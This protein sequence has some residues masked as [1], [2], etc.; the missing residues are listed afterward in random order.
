ML[1]SSIQ[2]KLAIG[3]ACLLS[4]PQLEHHTGNAQ[5]PLPPLL[6]PLAHRNKVVRAVRKVLNKVLLQ[7][8]DQVV[9]WGSSMRKWGAVGAGLS[10][11]WSMKGEGGGNQ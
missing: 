3:L 8:Q 11:G 4:T 6:E 10:G 9:S 5:Q 2:P 7:A 1:P